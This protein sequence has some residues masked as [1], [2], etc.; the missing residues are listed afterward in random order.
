MTDYLS[1]F[2]I[3][4]QKSTITQQNIS[5][6]CSISVKNKILFKDANI[7]C[8]QGNRYGFIGKNGCGKTT[9]LRYLSSQ[10]DKSDLTFLQVEQEVEANEKTPFEIVL[11]A[12]RRLHELTKEENILTDKIDDETITDEEMERYYKIQ[13]LLLQE[14][15]DKQEP[16]VKKIL[17]GLGF[18]EK[19]VDI[20][21]KNFSGG[22]RM[23]IS[24][25]RA[26]YYEPHVL[27]LDEPTNHLD[28]NAVVWLSDYLSKW[29]T[30][31]LTVSHNIGFL[32]NVC[33]NIINI[34]NY[35]LVNYKGNYDRF[36]KTMFK[37]LKQQEKDWN[38][39]EKKAKKMKKSGKKR[40]EINEFIK[41]SCVVKPEKPYKPFN[42]EFEKV[43]YARGSLIQLK[44]LTFGWEKNKILF[45][46]VELG[47][48]NDS[49]FTIVGNNGIGKSS[50]FQ[51]LLGKVKPISGEVI[52]NRGIRIGY[53]D[54]HFSESLPFEKS[55]VEYLESIVPENMIENSGIKQTVRKFLGK[56]GLEGKLHNNLIKELSGGQK[57]RVAFVALLFKQPHI[58]LLD[59]PTN[60]LD[61]ES[62]EGL[63]TCL[64]KF[65]GGLVVI[66][67]DT[68]MITELESQ[69]LVLED[70]KLTL[71]DNDFF[72]YIDY[73]L[74][75]LEN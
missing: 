66:T 32:N 31:L 73:L 69:L 26:L 45:E 50:L 55:A 71:W 44:N 33:T 12:N 53:Y 13:D 11:N 5:I 61:I 2:N 29:K 16:I 48:F 14:S 64:K 30:I 8:S 20:P 52:F 68:E 36:R 17:Y 62:I 65:N 74:E 38:K 18:R 25:A 47:I 28:L 43:S 57:A 3:V 70:K 59:E 35:K 10:L 63:I 67:H 23:R 37:K 39:I 42:V 4:P 34:E 56:I 60:H 9:F 46:D 75:K 22:W 19:E 6:G 40:N 7:N 1:N 51:V 21:S 27:L 58:I 54:Q 15:V 24:L 72:G 49:R 41:K